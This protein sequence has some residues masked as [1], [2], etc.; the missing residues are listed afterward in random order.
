MGLVLAPAIPEPEIEQPEPPVQE[1]VVDAGVAGKSV[2][3]SYQPQR[4]EARPQDP[5]DV[6]Q[7]VIDTAA[8]LQMDPVELATFLSYETAGTFN[9]RQPGPTTQWGQ[10]RGLIQ[11]GEPQ[12][13]QFGVD[14]SDERSAWASQLGPDGAIVKYALA[15]GFEPGM[16]GLDL[17]STINAG[18]PG[19]YGASDAANGGAPGTVADKYYEQM[20]GHRSNALNFFGGNLPSVD[21]RNY[22]PPAA[23]KIDE[24]SNKQPKTKVEIFADIFSAAFPEPQEGDYLITDM[25][26]DI[27]LDEVDMVPDPDYGEEPMES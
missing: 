7:G 24:A 13:S 2:T 20:D 10:H 15:H 11:F 4:P 19:R 9:P 8:A 21:P 12:A 22:T 5:Y 17:Y 27:Q 6:R 14:F 23:S 18:A 25:L 1:A 3:P 16:S 26:G